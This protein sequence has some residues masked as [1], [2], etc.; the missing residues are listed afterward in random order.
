VARAA[1]LHM[2]SKGT[3]FGQK[4]G[5]G[6]ICLSLKEWFGAGHSEGGN[7]RFQGYTFSSTLEITAGEIGLP[8][9][10]VTTQASLF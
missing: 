3:D 7:K 6:R 2:D 9:Y 5:Q 4:T 10:T 8:N 1:L